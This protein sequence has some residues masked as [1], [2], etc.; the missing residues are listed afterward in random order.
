MIDLNQIK[1]TIEKAANSN[2]EAFELQLGFFEGFTRRQGEAMA[3][4][5]DSRI[6]SLKAMAASADF[7][8][9]LQNNTAFE[10]DAKQ[11]LEK[12]HAEN[13]DAFAQFSE[14]LKSAYNI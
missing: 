13:V 1:E 12:L 10:A 3:E 2:K 14:S 11:R 8:N 9:A 7:E 6:N 4:L 5:A